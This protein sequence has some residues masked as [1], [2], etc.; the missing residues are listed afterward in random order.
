[1]VE[2]WVKRAGLARRE[3]DLA[4]A[5]IAGTRLSEREAAV[6]SIMR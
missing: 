1:M 3:I 5:W 4:V 6:R 2:A